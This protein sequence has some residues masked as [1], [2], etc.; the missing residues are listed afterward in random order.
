MVKRRVRLVIES[1]LKNVLTN[2]EAL[3]GAILVLLTKANICAGSRIVDKSSCHLLPYYF[4]SSL[5]GGQKNG[6]K[7]ES[8]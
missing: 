7:E 8:I 5:R 3:R 1:E 6:F 4:I 2:S